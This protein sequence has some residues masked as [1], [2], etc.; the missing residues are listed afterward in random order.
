VAVNTMLASATAALSA[1]LWMEQTT[2]WAIALQH[3]GRVL[4]GGDF[5][6]VNGESRG[7]IARL[8]ADGT[9]DN[10]FL[11][12]LS[13]LNGGLAF[14]AVQTD[15]RILAGGMFSKANGVNRGSIVRL[16]ADGTGD[17]SFQNGLSGVEYGW[18]Y[19]GAVQS[20]GR[21]PAAVKDHGGKTGVV[22]AVGK[23]FGY[24]IVS[25]RV[26]EFPHPVDFSPDVDC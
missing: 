17:N 23:K 10:S 21:I 25:V 4:I 9:L 26:H 13:G 7:R 20:D 11:D 5:T 18:I 2:L 3:D 19:S 22:Q 14:L 16:N 6:S 1:T 24:P 8:N 15:G 12:G